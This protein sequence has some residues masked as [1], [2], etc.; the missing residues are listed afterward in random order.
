MI[1]NSPPGTPVT[2]PGRARMRFAFVG[3]SGCGKS[4]VLLRYYRDTFTEA[5]TPTQYELFTKTA[6]LPNPDG[7]HD[8]VDLELWDTSGDIQLHQLQL[9]SYLR[10]DA[11]FLCFSVNSQKQF[12]RTQTQ[13]L[14]EIRM[15]C[16]DAP[17]ILVGLKKD[18][19]IGSGVWPPLYNAN[20]AA[21]IPSA[22]ACLAAH[23]HGAVRYMECSA[24]TGEGVDEI[25][26]EGM[27]T[28]FDERAADEEA[29]RMNMQAPPPSATRRLGTGLG[30]LFCFS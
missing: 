2:V 23:T 18:L 25:L 26:E 5:Y 14:R 9:L 3:D 17:V 7:S 30:R 16:R 15:N 24:K 21:A 12:D 28:V 1:S 10:W 11:V 13:W 4:S 29:I 8:D 22:R 6:T 20:L 19:R 27:R